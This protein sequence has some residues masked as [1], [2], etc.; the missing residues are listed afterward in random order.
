MVEP[1]GREATI[2]ERC[3]PVNC[4]TDVVF[5]QICINSTDYIGVDHLAQKYIGGT[6]YGSPKIRKLYRFF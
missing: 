4:E 3:S 1:L 6:A 2:N 5:T